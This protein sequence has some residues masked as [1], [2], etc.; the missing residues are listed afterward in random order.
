[1]TQTLY[2]HETEVLQESP[3]DPSVFDPIHP[4]AW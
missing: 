1:M 4:G 2:E 3:Y